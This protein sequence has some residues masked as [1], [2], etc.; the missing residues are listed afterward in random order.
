MSTCT[1]LDTALDD[2]QAARAEALDRARQ[3]IAPRSLVTGTSVAVD[4]SDLVFVADWILHG[5]PG[6]QTDER[7]EATR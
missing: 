4:A 1:D 2:Q 6:P 3:I 5:D 7:Q